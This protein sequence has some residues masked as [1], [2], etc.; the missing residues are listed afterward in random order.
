MQGTAK[1]MSSNFI[2]MP[3]NNIKRGSVNVKQNVKLGHETD[4]TG[5]KV[6]D[7]ASNVPS[8]LFEVDVPNANVGA[9]L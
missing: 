2:N 7:S 8:K 9:D 3:E 4:L 1:F 6:S 5:F